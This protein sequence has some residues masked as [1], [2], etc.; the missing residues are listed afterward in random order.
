MNI[1][2]QLIRLKHYS[3]YLKLQL[4]NEKFTD[5]EGHKEFSPTRCLK[6]LTEASIAQCD[7]ISNLL[8]ETSDSNNLI[9]TLIKVFYLIVN[10][11]SCISCAQKVACI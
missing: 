8:F 10:R 4:H 7:I 6:I 11:F 5:Y 9:N 2:K 1:H 3:S